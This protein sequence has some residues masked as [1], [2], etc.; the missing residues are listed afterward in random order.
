VLSTVF[1]AWLAFLVYLYVTTVYPRRSVAP[2]TA[3]SVNVQTP[4]VDG[5]PQA[6]R[7]TVVPLY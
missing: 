7:L 4:L 2:T 1:A 6:G 3:V 5:A